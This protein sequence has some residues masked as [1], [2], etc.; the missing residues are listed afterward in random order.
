MRYNGREIVEFISIFDPQ[1]A[2]E[3]RVTDGYFL[4]I[5]ETMSFRRPPKMKKMMHI[6]VLLLLILAIWGE[7]SHATSATYSAMASTLSFYLRNRKEAALRYLQDHA[8]FDFPKRENN[9]MLL[10]NYLTSQDFTLLSPQELKADR[11]AL[12]TAENDT[13]WV[14]FDLRRVLYPDSFL[15]WLFKTGNRVIREKLEERAEQRALYGSPNLGTL[16]VSS[17]TAHLYKVKDNVLWMRVK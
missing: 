12:F 11:E 1:T 9:I 7:A 16:P 4:C 14:G 17:D 13:V 6:T 10:Q 3:V 8:S 5:I 2:P 15:D